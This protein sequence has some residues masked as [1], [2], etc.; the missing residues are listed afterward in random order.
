MFFF[1]LSDSQMIKEDLMLQA[2]S[3]LQFT[4]LP[5]ER[6]A[7][8]YKMFLDLDLETLSLVIRRELETQSE[9]EELFSE[10]HDDDDDHYGE[11]EQL[12]LNNSNDVG[13]DEHE[14]QITSNQ[15]QQIKEE[16]AVIESSTETLFDDNK[17][18]ASEKEDDFI[19]Q[20]SPEH[21]EQ[22]QQEIQILENNLLED[23]LDSD[24]DEDI[25]ENLTTLEPRSITTTTSTTSEPIT[26]TTVGVIDVF[27]DEFE[28]TTHTSTLQTMELSKY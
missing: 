21:L 17:D 7:H 15:L 3:R 12:N 11:Y 16:V 28:Y 25:E 2:Y 20:L 24:V 19:L 10:D 6:Q 18:N 26:T 8:A 23:I 13:D 27:E 22:I 4:S 5:T 1:F 14:F 9:V